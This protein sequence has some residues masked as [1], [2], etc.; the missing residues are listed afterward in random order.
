ML[1][2]DDD[3]D[4][5]KNKNDEINK[6]QQNHKRPTKSPES[7]SHLDHGRQIPG[8]SGVQGRREKL[9]VFLGGARRQEAANA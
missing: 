2:D 1:D 9:D 4:D 8:A 7:P 3:N 5:D 6:Q